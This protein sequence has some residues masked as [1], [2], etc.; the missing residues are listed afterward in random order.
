M[1]REA[2]VNDSVRIAEIEVAGS[3]FAYGS[4]LSHECLYKDFTGN[5][6]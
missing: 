2:E 5:I 1:I 6:K 4:I 3:R